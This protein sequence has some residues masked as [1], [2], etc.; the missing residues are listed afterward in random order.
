MATSPEASHDDTEPLTIT[1]V[2][3]GDVF[4][5]RAL[6]LERQAA[7]KFHA[8]ARIYA[9]DRPSSRVKDLVDLVLMN[10]QAE[11]VTSELADAV[12]RVF[13]ERDGTEPPHTL[14]EP[15]RE[16]ERTYPP[17]ADETGVTI[18]NP[19]DAWR[20]ISATYGCALEQKL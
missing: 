3:I 5:V 8:Y 19:L 20:I 18:A 14:P 15:P 12:R 6:D 11:L 1:P 10:E 9:H 16:W 4:T 13:D 2:L 7:E 17:L